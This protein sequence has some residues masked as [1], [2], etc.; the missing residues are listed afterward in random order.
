MCCKN[1]TITQ[2]YTKLE[3]VE[4]SLSHSTSATTAAEGQAHSLSLKS[5]LKRIRQD[6]E[7]YSV[8]RI[9]GKDLATPASKWSKFVHASESEE[10]EEKEE[11]EEEEEGGFYQYTAI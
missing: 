4:Q 10:E 7:Q 5:K 2:R 3:E 9:G 11:E 1:S 8:G 6:I